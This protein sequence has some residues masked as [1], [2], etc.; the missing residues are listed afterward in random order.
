LLSSDA[1]GGFSRRRIEPSTDASV[2]V[3]RLCA[4]PHP[5]PDT[6]WA[7]RRGTRE[8]LSRGFAPGLELAARGRVLQGGEITV[9]IEGPKGLAHASQPAAVSYPRAGEP[10]PQ[11]ELEIEPRLARADA[12]DAPPLQD[13]L[14]GA[15]ELTRRPVRKTQL[16]RAR[17][18]RQ[19]RAFAR[20]QAE[21]AARDSAPPPPAAPK[22]QDQY[23]FTDPDRRIRPAGGAPH[24]EQSDNAPAAGEGDRRRLVGQRGTQATNDK[25]Q[26]VPTRQRVEPAAGSVQEVLIDRG[27]VSEQ[28][29]RPVER[30][31]P[32][33]PPGTGGLTAVQRARHGRTGAQLEKRADPPAPPDDAPF[34]EPLAHRTVTAAGRARDQLKPPTVAPSFGSIKEAIGFRRFLLRGLEKVSREWTL[35]ARSYNRRRRPTLATVLPATGRPGR[36]PCP[37]SENASGATKPE[38]LTSSAGKHR[39]MPAPADPF[40]KGGAILI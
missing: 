1:P 7:F 13:G 40:Q 26:L 2:A 25:E 29:G 20:A 3:R 31:E 14:T 28:A 34:L 12:A 37:G 6:I 24:F 35:G 15:G 22:T 19:A 33:Q 39:K 16:P 18:E 30:D 32:G 23:H 4:D 21:R 8:R 10:W 38:V 17:V 5:D 11:V 36:G 27:F 9:A